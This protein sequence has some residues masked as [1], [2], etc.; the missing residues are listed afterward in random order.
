MLTKLA[1]T[2][3]AS[4]VGPTFTDHVRLQTHSRIAWVVPT[5]NMIF[6]FASA[7]TRHAGRSQCLA[8]SVGRIIGLSTSF[9]P[10]V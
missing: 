3:P 4:K 1:N 8:I 7:E 2:T 6:C 9:V 10:A 5:V